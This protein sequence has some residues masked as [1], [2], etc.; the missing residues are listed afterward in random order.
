MIFECLV[1]KGVEGT[2]MNKLGL[3][4]GARGGEERNRRVVFNFIKQLEETLNMDQI[5]HYSCEKPQ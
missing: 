2:L 1:T 3:E 4:Q 5:I